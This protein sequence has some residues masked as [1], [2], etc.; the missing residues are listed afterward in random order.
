MR[1]VRI[2]E[3]SGLAVAEVSHGRSSQVKCQ[4]TTG[5]GGRMYK[6]ARL[7]KE[8]TH[9]QVRRLSDVVATVAI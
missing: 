7:L 6:D 2:V 1:V 9:K 4:Y 5:E 3:S 8:Y